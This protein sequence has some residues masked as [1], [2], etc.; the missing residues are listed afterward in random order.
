MSN[1][2]R[3]NGSQSNG[4]NRPAK[5]IRYRAIQ[6]TIWRNEGRNGLFYNTVITRSYKDG[7]EWR[8]SSAFGQEDLPT[9]AKAALDA[10]TWIQEQTDG[11]RHGESGATP[12][13]RQQRPRPPARQPAAV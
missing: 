13:Q 3:Q 7:E 6:C 5:T 2:N 11:D 9:V 12:P 4:G 10:H 8:E 1:S